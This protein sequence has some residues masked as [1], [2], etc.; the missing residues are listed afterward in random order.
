[1]S[2][3]P[4]Q[5]KA[6][7][8]TGGSLKMVVRIAEGSGP[9]ALL[10]RKMLADVG[11][12]DFRNAHVDEPPTP[13]PE[14]PFPKTSG[15]EATLD[16]ESLA[17]APRD[18][19]G[20]FLPATVTDYAAAY[21]AGRATPLEIA[22]RL[23]DAVEKS[24]KHDPAL[25][26]FIAQNRE[27]VL[28]QAKAATERL[29]NDSALGILDGVPVAVKDELDQ[30]GYPTTVGTRFMGKTPASRD[31]TVVARLR[32]AGAVLVGKANMH[33]IGLG[34]T[35]L[36]THHG[37]ARNPHDPG[38]FT[39]G[40]SSG[41]AAV[42]AAGICPLAVGADG[43]GSIR[44]PAGL[45]GVV[46]LKPTFGRVSEDGAAQL[47]WSVAH[48]GPIAATARDAA[49]GYAL[50]AG[51][52]PA[53]PH[54]LHQPPPALEAFDDDDLSGVVFGVYRPWL[55][56][57]DPGV[58]AAIDETLAG[59]K[60]A[61]AE[62]REIE[63]PELDLFSFAH[64]VTIASEM[65]ASQKPWLGRHK[66]EYGL[67]IR[68]NLA[69]ASGL[70]AD[71]YVHAQRIRTRAIRRFLDV[72]SEVDGIV[73]PTTGCTAPPI[74]PDALAV[75][76][77]DLPVLDRIMRFASFANLT[78]LPAI[79]FP[80]GHDEAGLP[81]GCQVIGRPWREDFL[82]RVARIAESFV[83]YRRP[84]WHA[85]LLDGIAEAAAA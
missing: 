6:P 82:L 33:E 64:L 35:G 62:I 55:E 76:E 5:M 19:G 72:L 67:D 1:M 18:T 79:S 11:I 43:G 78:G 40:S 48:V 77:S 22:E 70:H 58:V 9:G 30:Q 24:E 41:S 13:L 59:L 36:N 65:A 66:K 29:K 60:V 46:G 47:C 26:L 54:S 69:L 50:M 37:S 56:H 32:A 27:D 53:D 52:D 8:L 21:R 31:A 17:A 57:A 44:V 63:I 7:R 25:R 38:R 68:M 75:G 28:E 42:V 14:L 49:I 15:S 81:V 39:G 23:L 10:R 80:A 73:T 2:Y 20:P 71:D 51:P 12:A 3:Q 45:C 34:V 61:G 16:V 84:K 74:R 4:R 85:D 83:A